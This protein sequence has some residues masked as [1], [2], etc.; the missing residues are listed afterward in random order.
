MAINQLALPEELVTDMFD[1]VNGK[2]S[3]AV[4]AQS[5]PI[6]FAGTKEFVFSLDDDVSIVGEGEGKPANA[7][8][9]TPVVITPFK[10]VYQ[11]R[12]SSEFVHSS[13]E[14]RIGYMQRFAA[15][16]AKKMA[17]GLDI[18]AF[19]GL[20]PKTKTPATLL[21]GKS[22]DARI[23]NVVTYDATQP[24]DNLDAAIQ[25]ITT[26][27]REFNGIAMSDAFGAAMAR[28]KVNGVVQYPE[29]RFGGA[30]G[31][32]AGIPLSKNNTLPITDTTSG[33]SV[34]ADH[35]IVG[36]FQ[37]AFKWGY[38]K[39]IPLEV[40]EYGDPDGTGRDLKY[41]NEVCLRAE[42]FL[43]FGILDIASFAMIK[44]AATTNS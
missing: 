13:D 36:D 6:P 28:V 14:A 32:F 25:M 4:L 8:H 18:A 21:A 41:Y 43:G 10:M 26:G 9:F 42:A 37:N 3:V 19:H 20:N 38:A 15:G 24:D 34:R 40:I 27:Q 30:P 7:G 35:A 39:N 17:R 16:F 22:F 1:T 2:S 29:F 31:A 5:K 11:L 33:A 44:A 23:T 12:V